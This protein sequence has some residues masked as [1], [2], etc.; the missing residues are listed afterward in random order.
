MG[1]NEVILHW[2]GMSWTTVSPTPAT[3]QLDAIWGSAADDVWAVGFGGRAVHWDGMNW[4]SFSAGNQR[5]TSIF[6][7]S[8]TDIWAVGNSGTIEHFNGAWSAV[9]S[10]SPNWVDILSIWGAVPT[11]IWAVG[12]SNNN[13]PSNRL[14]WDGM[15]W[16]S[17]DVPD[18]LSTVAGL[19]RTDVWAFGYS[20]I[21]EHWDGMTWTSST[22]TMDPYTDITLFS[23]SDRWAIGDN[24]LV[25]RW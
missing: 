1:L 3:E 14:H 25:I 12:I 18:P 17:V 21:R 16:T 23:S 15:N 19:S 9:T 20:G 4:T 24:G 11:D 7:F 6:G 10:P 13:K 5:L 8:A 22:P 2:D